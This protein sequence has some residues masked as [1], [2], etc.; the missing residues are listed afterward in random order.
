MTTREFGDHIQLNHKPSDSVPH[1]QKHLKHVLKSTKLSAITFPPSFSLATKYTLSILDQGNL[2][3][4]VANAF[5]GI[6]QSL[7]NK[8][9]SRL[10]FYF[11][12]R[13]GTGNAPTDDSGLDILQS[14]PIL[15]SF[16]LVPET[17]WPYNTNQFRVIPP[18]STTFKIADTTNPVKYQSIDQNET[19]IKGALFANKF[20]ILG[21]A[22]Y[23]SFM[24]NQVAKTGMIPM[25]NMSRETNQGGHCIHLVGWCKINN[26]TY[27]I[28][29]NSWGTSWGNDGRVNPITNFVNNGTNGG[30][31]YI[32][33][34]YILN[35][36]L[37]FEIMAI[38]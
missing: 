33:A 5:A 30:F 19:A 38:G 6:M 21:I 22:V 28:I 8:N 32:P 1:V 3:S 37:S 13:V 4:C 16:G 15:S 34:A 26:Q 12:A 24:T 14:L 25:P 7:Y 31:A 23:S 36:N 29:R 18:F 10:Y 2:G 11:N 35:P 17:N 20:V 9:Y 27:Y